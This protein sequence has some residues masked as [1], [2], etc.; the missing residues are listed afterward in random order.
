MMGTAL[1][2]MPVLDQEGARIERKEILGMTT[3]PA[4]EDLMMIPKMITRQKTTKKKERTKKTKLSMLLLEE[5][6]LRAH[7]ILLLTVIGRPMNL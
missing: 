6:L 2:T 1:M 5:M 7:P 3:I 4:T